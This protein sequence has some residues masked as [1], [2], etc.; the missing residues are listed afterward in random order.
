MFL[1]GDFGVLLEAGSRNRVVGNTLRS[2]G[3]VGI[4]I[5][6][7]STPSRQNVIG[8]NTVEQADVA[9]IALRYGRITDTLIEGNTT[10]VHLGSPGEPPSPCRPATSRTRGTSGGR[11]Y[12]TTG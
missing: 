1:E 7:T 6:G 12:A 5:F 10:G 11:S 9:D 4:G 2:P 8:G 3:D